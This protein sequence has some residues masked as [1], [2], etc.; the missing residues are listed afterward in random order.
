MTKIF[1]QAQIVFTANNFFLVNDYS[2]QKLVIPK[3]NFLGSVL[4]NSHL[5]DQG[6]I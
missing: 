5:M 1:G 2:D 6:L 4:K 3:L